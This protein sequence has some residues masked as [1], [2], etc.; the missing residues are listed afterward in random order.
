MTD[1]TKQRRYHPLQKHK[2][3]QG[4]MPKA[5]VNAQNVE[6]KRELIKTV[7]VPETSVNVQNAELKRD[8][9]KKVTVPEVSVN[10]QNAELKRESIKYYWFRQYIQSKQWH[11]AAKQT[12]ENTVGVKEHKAHNIQTQ[13]LGFQNTK[14]N[15]TKITDK[16]IK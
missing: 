11:C 7:T 9:I 2:E 10:V 6:L 12:L 1:E 16:K 14:C 5:S 3:T 15:N 4:T 8:L 13:V